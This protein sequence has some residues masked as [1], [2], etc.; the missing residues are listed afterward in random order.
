V[1]LSCTSL[2]AVWKYWVSHNSD[3]MADLSLQQQ[4]NFRTSSCKVPDAALKLNN[5]R[6]LMAFFTRAVW[7]HRWSWQVR[8]CARAVFQFVT[9]WPSNI[10]RDRRNLS[11]MT[12]EVLNIMIV[13]LYSCLSYAACKSHLFFAVSYVLSS[14]ACAAVLYFLRHIS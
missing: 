12:Q 7:L 13:C 11:I 9:V 14:V 6:L 4:Y 1:L 3:L 2:S 8:R 5:V 10:V